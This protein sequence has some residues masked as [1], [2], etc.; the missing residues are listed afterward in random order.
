MQ[1]GTSA[2]A[3]RT[4]RFGQNL[5]PILE[6]VKQINSERNLRPLL[7][8]ILDTM[9]KHSNARRGTIAFFKGDR[10]NA[11]LSRDR[12]GKEIAHSDAGPLGAV[13]MRVRETEKAVLVDDASQDPRV[14]RH[15]LIPGHDP[16]SILA[17][18]LRVKDRLIGAIYLDNAEEAG[19]F[20]SPQRQFAE[21]LAE[22]AAIAVE[23]ALLHRRT[24][25]DRITDVYNHAHFESVLEGEMEKA[26]R[27][28]YPC[29]LLMIDVDDFKQIND[30]NGHE[31]G[32]D[33]LRNVAYTLSS[34]V[35]GADVVGRVQGRPPQAVVGRYGGDEFEIILP[36][37]SRDGALRTARR[38]V[39]LFKAQ[40]FMCGEKRLIISVSVGVAVFPDDAPDLHELIL[41]ADEALYQAKRAGKGRAVL[42]RARDGGPPSKSRE[43]GA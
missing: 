40:K 17:L 11:E 35:R 7:T 19:A 14:R 18:P 32:S 39:S 16:L 38:L 42:A 33:V 37:A 10:F 3:P 36:G 12:A 27:I 31:V 23:N 1:S 6:I 24:T 2:G 8:L 13:L 21:L 26:T 20:G 15:I 30:L 28:G 25:T 5:A 43:V 41:R 4:R 9:I 34:T 22:H 29:G